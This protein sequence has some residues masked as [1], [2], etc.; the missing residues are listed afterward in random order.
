MATNGKAWAHGSAT[1]PARVL[2]NFAALTLGQPWASHANALSATTRGGSYGVAFDGDLAV[3]TTGGLGYSVAAGRVAGPGTF[4]AAQGGYDGYNDAAV[5]G[6]VTARHATLTREDLIAWRVRDTDEDA[7]TFEDDGI[8]L[9][10]GTAGSGVPALPASL[11][12][13]VVLCQITVS[14]AAVNSAL[15]FTD[16]RARLSSLGAPIICTSST[17]PTGV[18]L[19]TPTFIYETDTASRLWH[20]GSTWRYVNKPPAAFTPIGLSAANITGATIAVFYAIKNNHVHYWGV[21]TL[22]AASAIG[23]GSIILTLP[24]TAASASVNSSG[25]GFFY[26][27][28]ANGNWPALTLLNTTTQIV[29]GNMQSGQ[30]GGVT[31]TSPFTWATGDNITF[32]IWYEAA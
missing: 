19:R 2:R 4:A 25:G 17:R 28:S 1:H 30:G 8:V 32:D 11:G 26:D 27:T 10:T 7:T 3:T 14:S 23:T 18:A 22:G 15:V 13:L 12:T 6:S 31:G 29:V 20:D 5:T 21:I 9:I 16:K 24:T